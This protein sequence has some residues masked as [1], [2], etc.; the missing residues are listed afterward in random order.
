MRGNTKLVKSWIDRA[1]AQGADLVAFP[2]LTLTGYPPEDLV[3]YPAFVAENRK[4]LQQLAREVKHVA[5]IVGFVDE[6]DGR[7]FNALALI[8]NGDVQGVYHK[9][10]LPNY[11]V[12]DERRYFVPGAVCPV[13]NLG[14]CAIGLNICEDIWQSVGPSEIQCRAGA[15]L[16]VNINGSPFEIDKRKTRQ[17]LVTSAARRNRAFVAYVNQVGGQDELVF[18]GGSMVARPDGNLL[19]SSPQFEEDLL[20]I[21]LDFEQVR[22]AP[23]RQPCHTS[24]R[25]GGSGNYGDVAGPRAEAEKQTR[26]AT[27]ADRGGRHSRRHLLGTR[28]RNPRLPTQDRIRQSG[29]RPV[30]RRRFVIGRRSGGG[31]PRR[32]KRRRRVDAVA[33][34]FRRFPVRRS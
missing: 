27:A 21:D 17:G 3:L 14:R 34:L 29:G 26:V 23:S 33:L 9:I 12:F 28:R 5:A 13:A 22:A 4:L 15:E 18:D 8:A 31:R 6:V 20:V 16:I 32:A 2:E 7:L 10:H 24:R 30:G 1:S 25:R 11:G 19:A